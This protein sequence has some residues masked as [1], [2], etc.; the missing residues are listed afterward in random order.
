MKPEIEIY[1]A[2]FYRRTQ[3][4]GWRFSIFEIFNFDTGADWA[5]FTIDWQPENAPN[6]KRLS[7]SLL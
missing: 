7:F 2:K 4:L 3:G 6:G 1:I 5:L